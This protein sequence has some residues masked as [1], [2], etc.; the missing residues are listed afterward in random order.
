[1]IF[2]SNNNLFGMKHPTIRTTTSLG[3]KFGYAHYSNWEESVIDYGI[4]SSKYIPDMSSE[5]DYYEFL[6]RYYAQD[7]E[8][9]KKL[10]SIVIEKKLKEIFY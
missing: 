3:T 1:M 8:Y 4:Y 6:N 5:N 7:P 2:N 10:K 9:S